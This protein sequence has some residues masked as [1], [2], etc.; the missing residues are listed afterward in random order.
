MKGAVWLVLIACV[1]MLLFLIIKKR[2][3]I[4]WLVVFGAHMGLAAI[5]LYVINYSGWITQV[6][7][8]INPV[9]MGAVT[10]LGLPG[11]VLL[12]G[13]KIILFGQAI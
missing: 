8:P 2:L 9:T 4:G 6:Y 7:I 1:G 12:L 5:A 11:I 10:I 3:G 13:L